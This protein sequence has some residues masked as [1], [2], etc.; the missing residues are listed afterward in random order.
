MVTPM[1]MTSRT[2]VMKMKAVA[3]LRGAGGSALVSVRR[4]NLDRKDMQGL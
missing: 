2:M 3:A 1:A 4:E